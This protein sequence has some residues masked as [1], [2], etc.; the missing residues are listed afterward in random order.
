MSAPEAVLA[1]RLLALHRARALELRRGLG[2]LERDLRTDGHPA[3]ADAARS[4]ADSFDDLLAA[5]YQGPPGQVFACK[6]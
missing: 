2:A 4:L 5:T 3:A 6:R 1:A